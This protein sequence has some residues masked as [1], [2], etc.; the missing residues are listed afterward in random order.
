[1]SRQFAAFII[2]VF[3]VVGSVSAA[4]TVLYN[5]FG[6]GDTYLTDTGATV[7]NIFSGNVD[8]GNSFM[9]NSST[10]S[11]LYGIE[12]AMGLEFGTNQLDLLLMSDNAGLPGA[13]IETFHFVDQML[14]IPLSGSILSAN[15][16]LQP[17]LF[18]DTLYWLVTST[19][20]EDTSA[21]WYFSPDA[22]GTRIFRVD[23][24]SWTV[25]NDTLQSAF[26]VTGVVIPAPGAIILG[27][28]GAGF[29]GWLRRRRTI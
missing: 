19:S 10:P 13:I 27:G 23:D 8:A 15:S 3:F 20:Y 22:T 18:P 28:I 24:G 29:V 1:M 14:Q 9:I 26:R 2:T 25:L 16:V 7:G 17:L 4:P 21:I 5:T 11:K 12:A 6:A